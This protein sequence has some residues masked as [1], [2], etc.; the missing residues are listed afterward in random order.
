MYYGY[1]TEWCIS[2][3]NSPHESHRVY[4]PTKE[5]AIKNLEDDG[6]LPEIDSIESI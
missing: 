2:G 5:E 6:Q 3:A 4:G 1:D